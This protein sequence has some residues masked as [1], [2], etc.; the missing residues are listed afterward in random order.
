MAAKT[1]VVHRGAR[2]GYHVAR[3]LEEAG[4]LEALVT[5]LYWP[6]DHGWARFAER[7]SPSAVVKALRKRYSDGLPA[8]HV[9]TCAFS[10]VGS[11]GIGK[12]RWT[13]FEWQ[14][15]AIRWSDKCLGEYAGRLAG[16]RGAALV[17]Y[18]YYAYNAFSSVHGNQPR[19]LFQVHPHPGR[20]REILEQERVAYPECASS[21]DKEWELALPPEDFERL[22]Q[23]SGMADHWIAASS[24]TRQ[25]LV[26]S[27]VAGERISVIP[28]GV[29]LNHFCPDFQARTARP[30]NHKLRLLFVGTITQRK[31]I[32]YLLEAIRRFHPADL[33]LIVCGRTVDSLDLFQPFKDHVQVRPFVNAQ[34]LLAAYQS[35]D[36]FV[37]P[38]LAEGFG[39]VLL[40]AMASGLPIVST[41][42]TAAPDLIRSGQEGFIL[43]PGDAGALAERID[44]MMS[45]RRDLRNM[46]QAARQTAEH[47]TWARFRQRV[48]EVVGPI[49]AGSAR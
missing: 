6:G 4:L 1:V 43:G 24:F 15:R 36:A 37:F 28:Y 33:E 21:L 30:N 34:E 29:D 46:G 5:D 38:S 47:F 35:A 12:L 13:P 23:E 2:D 18:S 31:G 45:H 41:T 20:V 9:K 17:S 48:A 7:C 25:T 32:K 42:R 8:R 22:V 10:G 16:R 19:I 27:G 49:T 40:E 3:A 11:F 14:R 26:E 44:W 39:H